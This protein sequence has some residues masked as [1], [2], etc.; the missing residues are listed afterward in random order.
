MGWDA[1]SE[2]EAA[3]GATS[4]AAGAAA[5]GAGAAVLPQATV[6]TSIRLSKMVNALVTM[7]IPPS[8]IVLERIVPNIC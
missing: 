2:P 4:G 7:K 6:R 5:G 1:G 8:K 3:G